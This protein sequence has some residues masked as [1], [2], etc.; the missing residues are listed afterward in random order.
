[1]SA[2]L[3]TDTITKS[4][5]AGLVLVNPAFQGYCG[6]T[7]LKT[8]SYAILDSD[9]YS[10][11]ECDT[12]AG[13]VTI[14][15]PLKSTNVGRIVQIANIKGGTNKVIISPNATDANK[16]SNDGL[17]VIWLPK[18]GDY[19]TFQESANSGFWEIINERISSQFHVR[20][21][22]GMGATD[23]KIP[24]FTNVIENYGNMFSENHS[25]GYSSNQKGLEITI[26]RSGRYAFS[27]TIYEST[28]VCG[29]SLNSSQLTTVVYSINE[30]DILSLDLTGAGGS[31]VSN[32]TGWLVKTSIVRPH[33]SA[34]SPT[35]TIFT[36]SY[37]G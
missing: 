22:A 14:T 19:A 33:T 3:Y 6:L 13:D 36:V 28:D 5:A 35:K 24:R 4:T 26:N 20:T 11:I 7:A 2:N 31:G 1:M 10:R 21:S 30:A 18:I 23:T 37:L 25:T 32:W 9:N 8:A 27:Y 34:G 29:L 15:L 17:N 12:T 16:L